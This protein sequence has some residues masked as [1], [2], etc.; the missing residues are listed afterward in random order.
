MLCLVLRAQPRVRATNHG[1]MVQQLP[2]RKLLAFRLAKMHSFGRR[3]KQNIVAD[4]GFPRDLII[5]DATVL[6]ADEP[7]QIRLLHFL[8]IAHV[9]EF[10]AEEADGQLSLAK[11]ARSLHDQELEGRG[12]AV[13]KPQHCAN[14]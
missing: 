12:A 8:A 10:M 2:F 5:E 13:R 9:R 4:G 7:S 11:A 3:L 6:R 14:Q 1:H